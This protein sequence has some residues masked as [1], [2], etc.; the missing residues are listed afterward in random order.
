VLQLRTTTDG[1]G[2]GVTMKKSKK[3]LSRQQKEGNTTGLQCPD[4]AKRG[5]SVVRARVVQC[6]RVCTGREGAEMDVSEA[7]HGL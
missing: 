2:N 4:A 3:Q 7:N 6:R 5:D 1:G